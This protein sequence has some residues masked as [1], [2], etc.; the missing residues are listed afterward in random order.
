MKSTVL[1]ATSHQSCFR[2]MSETPTTIIFQKVRQYTSNLYCNTPP[3]CITMLSVPLSSE[4]TEILSDLPFGPQYASHLYR[5]TPPICIAM[6]W[7]NPAWPRF[8]SVQSWFVRRVP[9]APVFGADGSCRGSIFS[10]FCMG[11][12]EG[13]GYGFKVPGKR[14]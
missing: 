7:E 13:D 14:F 9:A 8:G 1:V 6:L 3:L 5:N 2:R 12:T 11:L 10:V 4:E